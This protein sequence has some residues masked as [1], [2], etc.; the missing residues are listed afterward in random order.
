MWIP[1]VNN[2]GTW[3]RWAFIEIDDPWDTEHKLRQSLS[4][5]CT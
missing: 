4:V 2:A 1:A 5:P 3:G